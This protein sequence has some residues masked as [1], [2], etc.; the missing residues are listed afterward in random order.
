MCASDAN[1][2][3]KAS[4]GGFPKC[5]K[6]CWLQCRIQI[7]EFIWQVCTRNVDFTISFEFKDS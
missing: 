2:A 5:H 1:Y 4:H 6:K 3:I 7:Q